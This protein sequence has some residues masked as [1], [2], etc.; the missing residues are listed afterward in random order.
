MIGIDLF[1]GAGGMSLGAS[2]AG[3]RV[4][5][6]VDFDSN[7]SKTYATN[8]PSTTVVCGDIRT[9]TSRQLARLKKV[10]N[11]LVVFGGPPCQ[12]FSWSNLRTRNLANESNWLFEEFL[13]VVDEIKPAWVVFENVQGITN[14][15]EG[16]ILNQ[17]KDTLGE[18]Y[19]LTEQL[20]NAKHFGVP[21]DRMRYFLV[22]SREGT[23]FY[24][25]RK[26]TAEPLTVDDAIRDLP[27]LQNGDTVSWRKY[28]RAFPS[29]YGLRLRGEAE[30][31]CNHL[32]T[33]NA[34]FVVKRYCHVPQGGNWEDIPVRLMQ[35]YADRDRCHTG[36]YHRLALRAPSIVI[37]NFRKN[38]LIHPTQDRGLSVREAA[39]IQSFPD[40][41]TFCGSIGFQ[42]QQ[43]GNAVPPLLAHAVFSALADTADKWTRRKQS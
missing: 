9:L 5:L 6:A 34:A 39:R 16:Q 19:L 28:G 1:A 36:I 3:I 40:A 17:I 43:V 25:P 12:G 4:V 21:Q 18:G 31:C 14:T 15:A 32:V 22:G 20:L 42:Q 27:V 26:R 8:H 35:N 41:Y 29:G 30:G 37:G 33:R 13:R 38:M 2:Q 24:F 11:E 10:R 23:T 7:A